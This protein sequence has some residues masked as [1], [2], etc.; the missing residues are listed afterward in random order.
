M[1][2]LPFTRYFQTPEHYPFH[3]EGENGGAALLVHGFPGSPA[4]MRPLGQVLQQNG[5]TVEGILLPGFGPQIET[6][7]EQKMEDWLEAVLI[8]LRRLK[9]SHRKVLAVGFSMGAA[10]VMQAAVQAA[11]QAAMQA[12]AQEAVDGAV[13]L[14]PYWKLSGP[15]WNLL[16]LVRWLFPTIHPFKLVRLDLGDPEFRRG[17]LQFM[18]ELDLDDLAA[19][20]KI[21]QEMRQFILPTAILVEVRR[22]GLNAGDCARRLSYPTLVLQGLQDPL[23]Q[24]QLTRQLLTRLPGNISYQEFEAAHDLPR[25]DRPAWP[26]VAQAVTTFADS[27]L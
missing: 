2:Y 11:V 21:L 13:L 23:V 10:L 19:R 27:L 7:F 3:M 4:E 25:P 22:T 24:P 16:P 18:P 6:L 9:A 5:W 17:M 26:Q 8:A 20:Q 12:A 15:A 14:A 1:D